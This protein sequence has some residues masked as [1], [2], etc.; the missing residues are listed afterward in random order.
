MTTIEPVSASA[1]WNNGSVLGGSPETQNRQDV[2][3]YIEEEIYHRVGSQGYGGREAPQSV[4][5]RP[6]K[7]G[8]E[9]KFSPT[10]K[11]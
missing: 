11:A 2:F 6:R 4:R 1:L 5:W 9:I 10:S 7:A 8:S 3:R